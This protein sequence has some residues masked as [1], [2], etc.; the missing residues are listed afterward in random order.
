MEMVQGGNVW[1]DL[2]CLLHLTASTGERFVVRRANDG[3]REALCRVCLLTGDG[4]KDAS[5]QFKDPLILGRRWVLPYVQL[6]PSVALCL[7][8]EDNQ[9]VCGYA[10]GCLDTLD[11]GE[12]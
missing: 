5:A 1:L 4:G 8:S 3:D 11:F 9:E 7:V 12:A 10:L 6:E 2:V